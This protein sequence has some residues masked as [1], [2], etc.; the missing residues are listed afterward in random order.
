M[1]QM[2][3]GDKVSAKS[4]IYSLGLV[5]FEICTHERQR[6][7]RNRPLRCAWDLTSCSLIC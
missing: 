5:F 6:R 2:M 7:G 3:M 1:L 4:D